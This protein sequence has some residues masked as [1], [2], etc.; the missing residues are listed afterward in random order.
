MG[1]RNE[2]ITRREVPQKIKNILKTQF[3]NVNFELGSNFTNLTQVFE[4]VYNKGV[5]DQPFFNH[6]TQEFDY[7]KI[8]LYDRYYIYAEKAP[9]KTIIV[10]QIIEH[11][12]LFKKI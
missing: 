12:D 6:D 5:K 8:E 1:K 2:I 10:R 9:E 7:H 3:R 11:S 4:I